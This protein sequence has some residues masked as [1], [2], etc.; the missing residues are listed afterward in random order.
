MSGQT[1]LTFASP[2][3]RRVGQSPKEGPLLPGTT[4]P[5]PPPKSLDGPAK[6]ARLVCQARCGRVTDDG[7]ITAPARNGTSCLFLSFAGEGSLESRCC[8]GSTGLA[9]GGSVQ[10]PNHKRGACSLRSG[11]HDPYGEDRA[12]SVSFLQAT[13]KPIMCS[14]KKN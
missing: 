14:R 9:G 3:V 6:H 5:L 1:Q 8:G 10:A 2:P 4:V 11:R 13:R 7:Q 12:C